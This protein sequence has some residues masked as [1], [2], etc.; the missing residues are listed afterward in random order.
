MASPAIAQVPVQQALRKADDFI[1][2]A[3]SRSVS[4]LSSIRGGQ[5]ED[6]SSVMMRGATDLRN[7]KHEIEEQRREIAYLHAQVEAAR[8]QKDELTHRLKSVKEAAKQSLQTSSKSLEALRTSVHELKTRSENS[9]TIVS[10]ARS[11]LTD[12]QELR[13]TVAASL[14]SLEPYLE[15][16]EEWAR[17]KETKSAISDLTLECSK[18]QQVADLLRDRLQSVGGELIE[19]KNRVAELEMAQT[20]DRAALSRANTA[21]TRTTEEVSS[22]AACIKKQ[23]GEL[24]D[25]LAVAAESEAKLGTANRRIKELQQLLESQDDELQTLRGIRHE[26]TR[27]QE[28]VAEKEAYIGKLEDAQKEIPKLRS[29]LNDMQAQIAELT[30]LDGSKDA[31]IADREAR[32]QQLA[33]EVRR[34]NNEIRTL[35]ENIGTS[36]AHEDA[37]RSDVRTARG[38]KAALM[39]RLD[40]VEATLVRAREEMEARATRLLEASLQYQSLEERFEDQSVT[41]RITREAAGDAQ[42]RLQAA[43]ALHAK[44][45]TE[46]T[47]KL[48]QEIA[49]LREQKLGLQATIDGMTTAVKR[50]EQTFEILRG[51]HADRIK[52]LGEMHETRLKQEE[53]H[54]QELTE[55]LVDA[56]GRISSSEANCT[57][58]EDEICDLRSQLREAQLP[59]PDAEAELRALRTRVATLEATDM[60]NTLRARTIESRYRTGDLNDEEKAFINTLVRTSQAVHEQELVAN[61]NEL[62]RRDNALKEMRAK[63]HLLESTLS[64]QLNA[65][66][67]KPASPTVG[68]RSMIDPTAWMSSGQSSSPAH[69][70]DRDGQTDVDV[71]ITAKASTVQHGAHE[72]LS[73]DQEGVIRGVQ[74]PDLVHVSNAFILK[75]TTP[76]GT[77]AADLIQKPKFS[78]LA[79]DCS[80]EIADFDDTAPR[81]SSPL[82]S[83]GKRDKASSPP[84]N[85]DSQVARKPVKRPRTAAR[86]AEALGQNGSPKNIGAKK[87][88]K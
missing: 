35:Y 71:T 73:S 74:P 12:V 49:V 52:E 55:N 7:A 53:K 75:T 43:E 72:A 58:L 84:K 14:R 88:S 87:V 4:V 13:A 36:K 25:T 50:Q 32:N 82:S 24:Y 6:I 59:S 18:S 60:R 22:L 70:P 31:A 61:R 28:I 77:S 64:K 23:Q 86:K 33:D 5:E 83:L 1:P 63:V 79:T 62:R 67:A 45:F 48:E 85:D 66:K 68:A 57:R 38:E 81:K 76:A 2:R 69:A 56:R 29:A 10:D 39:E 21:I 54:I 44:Q 40:G 27:L 8:K 78:K 11:S 26:V 16:G 30:S 37:A 34:Q 80:D 65:S 9:F 41:L 47:A 20:E 46:T 19:A 42:E 51:E 3:Q 15:G 17:S